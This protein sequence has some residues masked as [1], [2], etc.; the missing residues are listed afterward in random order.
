VVQNNY[1]L[2]RWL[3]I[4]FSHDEGDKQVIEI[5]LSLVIYVLIDLLYEKNA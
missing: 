1:S 2:R 4:N 5:V 3:M